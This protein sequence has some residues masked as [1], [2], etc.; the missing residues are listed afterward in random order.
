MA[1]FSNGSEGEKLDEQ[2]SQCPLGEGACPVF[3]VQM[4]HNYDQCGNEK[5]KAAMNLLINEEG[6]CQMRQLLMEKK[7]AVDQFHES[8]GPIEV[9]PVMLDWAKKH[10]VKVREL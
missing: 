6:L 2:C 4:L 8:N 9:M 5:L 10:G 7:V 3:L 1:Y